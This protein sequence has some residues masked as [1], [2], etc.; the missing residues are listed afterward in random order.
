MAAYTGK[1]KGHYFY[2]D[3]ATFQTCVSQPGFCRKSYRVSTE[4][5][6]LINTKCEKPHKNSNICLSKKN[7]EQVGQTFGKVFCTCEKE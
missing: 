1:K 6:E 3:L 2:T 4:I 5:V 7:C